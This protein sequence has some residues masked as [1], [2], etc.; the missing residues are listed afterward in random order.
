[1]MPAKRRAG[2]HL[3][4]STSPMTSEERRTSRSKTALPGWLGWVKGRV[5]VVVLETK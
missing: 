2:R 4:S 5:G 1:M 3:R